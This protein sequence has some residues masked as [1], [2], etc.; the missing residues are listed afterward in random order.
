MHRFLTVLIVI[1]AVLAWPGCDTPAGPSAP[2][3]LGYLW[4]RALADAA[5]QSWNPDAPCSGVE[6]VVDPG[7]LLTAGDLFTSYWEFYYHGGESYLRVRVDPSGDLSEEEVDA[8]EL[9]GDE[10][11]VP[12]SLD[13]PAILDGVKA[14]LQSNGLPPSNTE[15]KRVEMKLLASET[16]S[17][18][19]EIEAGYDYQTPICGDWSG[20][21]LPEAAVDFKLTGLAYVDEFWITLD[22]AGEYETFLIERMVLRD[23]DYDGLVDWFGAT[24]WFWD[25][26]LKLRVDG[27]IDPA[28]AHVDGT[29]SWEA[30]PFED[31]GIWEADWEIFRY[32]PTLELS[33]DPATGEVVE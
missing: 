19:W 31:E 13:S 4:A 11:A 28:S 12:D 27:Y 29:W 8:S 5:A 7:G 15:L 18:L 16:S 14:H 20:D 22:V 10:L 17:P 30:S 25:D 6:G 33:V 32:Y 9:H 1:A 26:T 23:T 3:E 2:A 21:T 24:A